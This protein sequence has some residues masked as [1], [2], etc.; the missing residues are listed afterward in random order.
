MPHSSPPAPSKLTFF[1]FT[2]ESLI[3]TRFLCSVAEDIQP[4]PETLTLVEYIVVEYVTNLIDCSS[5][6]LKMKREDVS[7]SY[8]H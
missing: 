4:L 6:F 3:R 2:E 5:I 1:I 7:F 8:L